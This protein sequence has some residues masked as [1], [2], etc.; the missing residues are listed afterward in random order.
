[1]FNKK[2]TTDRDYTATPYTPPMYTP[3]PP[4]PTAPTSH[5]PETMTT[6]PTAPNPNA[7]QATSASTFLADGTTFQGN[8][9]INGTMR[10]EGKADGDLEATES[11]VVGKTG[12]VQANLKTRRA[13]LNGKFSG[14]IDASDRV[15]LQAGSRV[16]AEIH[17]KNMVMEDGVQFSGNCRVGQ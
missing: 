2:Q 6:N 12:L 17:A 11:I 3:E 14:K 8:A 10:I 13:V 7:N 16:D 15:E 9:H 4:T 1:M 5:T